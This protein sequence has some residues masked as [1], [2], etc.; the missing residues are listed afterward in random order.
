MNVRAYRLIKNANG[1]TTNSMIGNYYY[2]SFEK[3]AV[4]KPFKGGDLQVSS[5][6]V[7]LPI[8]LRSD[9][10]L[11]IENEWFSILDYEVGMGEICRYF[12][13]QT[14]RPK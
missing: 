14:T 10:I 6:Q 5:A 12:L 4:Q 7:V 11:E 8:K 3:R 9:I 13:K 2:I 1:S